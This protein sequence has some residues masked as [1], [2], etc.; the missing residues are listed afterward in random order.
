MGT[1]PSEST[2]DVVVIGA[3]PAGLAAATRAASQSATVALLDA[4]N[5]PGGQYWRQ[6]AGSG[7]QSPVSTAVHHDVAT[8]RQ[9]TRALGDQCERG[10]VRY[11][12]EHQ[13]WTVQSDADRF[14]VYAVDRSYGRERERTVFGRR[15]VLA[16][17]AYDR[18]VPFPGW[19]LPGVMTAGGAQALLKGHGV[20]A[21]RRVVVAGTG[22]FLLPVAAGLAA[23]GAEVAG[24]HEAASPSAWLRQGRAVLENLGRLGEGLGYAKTLARHRVPVR[25]GSVLVAAH[26]HRELEAVTVAR[27][28]RRGSVVPGSQRTIAADTLAVGWG[29]T[30]QLELAL[31]VGCATKVDIDDSRVC[32]VDDEQQ[33]SV[34]GVYVA[35][36]TCG[37]G[38]AA[39]AVIEGTV[40]G[41]AAAGT[42]LTNARQRRRRAALRRFAAAM[43][44]AH[45][46]PP[47]WLSQVEPDTVVCRCEEVTVNDLREAVRLGA[48]NARSAKLLARPGMGWCQGRVC[49]Y[50]T[51]CLTAAWSQ[52]RYSAEVIGT[53]SVATP[54]K[55]GTLAQSCGGGTT[56][57]AIDPVATGTT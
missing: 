55:L 2:F 10:R 30:P 23:A 45:P 11:L 19:D 16:T 34:P 20:R 6:P 56:G 48:D 14:A 7:R 12:P 3:G 31:A 27:V 15:L 22:P 47:H 35:G 43:H 17:G 42:P 54:V 13:V 8:Y 57:T 29:F 33:S 52:T 28:A 41:A 49:G 9:L 38:G 44:S 50:A 25:T 18:Q 39:L 21:G 1:L 24:V 36:E 37:V 32:Q 4:G 53:R 46:V 26:G 5:A 40:A 51:A